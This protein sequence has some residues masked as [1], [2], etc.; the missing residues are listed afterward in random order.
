M[1][2]PTNMD[3]EDARGVLMEWI[4]FLVRTIQQG[5]IEVGGEIRTDV[6]SEADR[7]YR[8]H[9]RSEKGQPGEAAILGR[10]Q[11]L[12][13]EQIQIL[14]QRAVLELPS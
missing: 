11:T 7:K 4:E 1:D 9:V 2:Q 13:Q 8:V 14:E 5:V 6:T 3:H 10:I 12:D